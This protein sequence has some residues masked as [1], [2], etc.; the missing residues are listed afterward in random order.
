MCLRFALALLALALLTPSGHA[1]IRALAHTDTTAGNHFGAAVALDA[2]RGRAVVGATGAAA[3]GANAGAAYV[4]EADTTGAFTERARLQPDDCAPGD[5]FGRAVALSGDRVLVAAGGEVMDPHRP[6][7][8]YLFERDAA[9]AWQQAATLAAGPGHDEGYFAASIALD[10]DRALV[11]TAGD[12]AQR[13]YGGAAYVFER[14]AGGDWNQ[15]ARLEGSAG[16]GAGVFG[17]HARLDGVRALVTASPY[18]H[19]GTGSVYVFERE[20]SGRWRETAHL[21]GIKSFTVCADLDGDR[22]LVGHARAGP[23]RSG[24]AALYHR[25]DAGHWQRTATLVPG[26]P[27][28]DGSFGDAVSLDGDRA[29]VVGYGEQLGLG[30]NVDR[31]VYSFA[32]T[33]E[34]GWAQQQVMDVGAWAFG[35]ALDQAGRTALIGAASDAQPGAAYL[36]E[37]L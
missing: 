7:R 4:F 28:R 35:A 9:G 32:Y 3:C 37:L 8:A 11:T 18:D 30:Y 17:S 31:V 13:A 5:L 25:T 10:G 12:P 24:L 14:D 16:T 15:T 33:P 21:G 22:L 6:N 26:V 27:Y 19:E 2:E 20:P 29:L 34:A 1:Q 36:V 23:N